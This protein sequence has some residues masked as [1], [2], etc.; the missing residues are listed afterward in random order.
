MPEK[1]YEISEIRGRKGEVDETAMQGEKAVPNCCVFRIQ[2]KNVSIKTETH[3]NR[4]QNTPKNMG[5]ATESLSLSR[6]I[7]VIDDK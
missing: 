6:K 4:Q 5:I 3:R 1:V 7:K 2:G